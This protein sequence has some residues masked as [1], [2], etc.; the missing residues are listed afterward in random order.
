MFENIA[1]NL[2]L[3]KGDPEK[4]MPLFNHVLLLNV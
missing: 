4:Y 3:K 1:L 2:V